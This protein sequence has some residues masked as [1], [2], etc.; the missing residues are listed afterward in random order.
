MSAEIEFTD[1]P[2]L[3][4]PGP[5]V[6]QAPDVEELALPQ[7]LH[8]VEELAVPIDRV[9]NAADIPRER[10]VCCNAVRES[11]NQEDAGGRRA[12]TRVTRPDPPA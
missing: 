12:S 4:D 9:C 2:V 10:Q 5:T 3:Q 1:T 6:F 7:I 11:G 8:K